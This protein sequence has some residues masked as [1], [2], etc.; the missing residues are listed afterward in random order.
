MRSTHGR[1]YGVPKY[2]YGFRLAQPL[3]RNDCLGESDR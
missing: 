2:D 3:M 1:I